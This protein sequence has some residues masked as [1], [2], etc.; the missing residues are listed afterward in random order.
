MKMWSVDSASL[1]IMSN[2]VPF[3]GLLLLLITMRV[4][5]LFNRR[6]NCMFVLAVGINLA[7]IV[8]MSADF[9]LSTSTVE[10]A[11]LWR[12]FTS[13]LNFAC[14]P[15]IPLLLYK[16]FE[17]ET[18]RGRAA[19]CIPAVIN[20][21]LCTVSIFYKLVF[22]ISQDNG[23]DRGPL[24]F[25]PFATSL[26]YIAVIF[27]QPAKYQMQSKR[28]ERFVLMSIIIILLISMY[29]EIVGKLR[30]LTWTS[31][32]IGLILYYLLLN[33]HNFILDPLTGVY[34]RILYT[35]T[36][37][38]MNGV[39]PCLLALIDINEFKLVN[40]HFGHE[41][42]DRCLILFAELLN[43]CFLGCA[44]LYRIGGDE[45]VLIAKGH[46]H[47]KFPSCLARAKAEAEEAHIRFS[48]GIVN[49]NGR[50]DIDEALRRVDKSMYEEKE[51]MKEG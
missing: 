51:H 27:F 16:I 38:A 15:L 11:W 33:I 50:E 14:S 24:F 1:V 7:M 29:L 12:R 23:Y 30:F 9:M 45:F 25:I 10:T 6:Q 46:G 22:S 39:A 34:N 8:S 44:T 4:N 42:G 21:L 26:L 17:K 36:L 5:P 48:C 35:K 37:N 49:Y 20:L 40:D 31:S 18:K 2:L 19:I 13:F 28:T 3:L 47:E 43:R 32:A 41:A